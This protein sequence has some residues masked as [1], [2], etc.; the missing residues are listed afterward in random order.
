MLQNQTC[1]RCNNYALDKVSTDKLCS[2][3]IEKNNI[4]YFCYECLHE[5]MYCKKCA[6]HYRAI[7]IPVN[8]LCYCGDV[9]L[10]YKKCLLCS[11]LCYKKNG[12]L[13]SGDVSH[14]KI[15]FKCCKSVNGE[16]I[17]E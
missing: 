8:K 1:D 7:D 6:K 13:Y 12:Q 11:S 2:K 3:Y 14:D 5:Q 15:L 10:C 4:C 16:H 9:L 17:I